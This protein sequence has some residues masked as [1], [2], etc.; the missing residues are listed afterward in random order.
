MDVHALF[1]QQ[2]FDNAPGGTRL[3]GDQIHAQH[4]T[5][6]VGGFLRRMRQLYPSALAAATRVDLRLH[7]HNVGLETLRPFAGFVLGESH[8]AARGGDAVAR[9]DRLRLILVN[10]H[11]VIVPCDP[12]AVSQC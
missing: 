7:H 10:L 5:C 12:R 11:R 2:A 1:D 8:F 3:H 9:K 4:V 6:D